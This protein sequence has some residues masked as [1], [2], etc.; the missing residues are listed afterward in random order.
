[1]RLE[2]RCL[3]KWPRWEPTACLDVVKARGPSCVLQDPLPADTR[4]GHHHPTVPPLRG[5]RPMMLSLLVGWAGDRLA[6]RWTHR[7]PSSLLLPHAAGTSLYPGA[8]SLLPMSI[9]KQIKVSPR[10]YLLQLTAIRVMEMYFVHL[11]CS[12]ENQ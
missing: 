2:D 4:R 6:W 12:A 3:C 8:S 5:C 7:S 11:Q 9:S 1:M 10:R